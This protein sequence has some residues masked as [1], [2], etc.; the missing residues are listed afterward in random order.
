[1]PDVGEPP[2]LGDIAGIVRLLDSTAKTY[3]EI[4]R[5]N[6]DPKNPGL[7]RLRMLGGQ[8]VRIPHK[9]LYRGLLHPRYSAAKTLGY[10]GTI[11]RWSELVTETTSSANPSTPR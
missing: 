8:M 7:P 11:D 5:E 4:V 6:T 1:M 2:N 10:R 3:A 9:T